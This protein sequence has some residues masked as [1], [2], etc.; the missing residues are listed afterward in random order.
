MEYTKS[1]YFVRTNN[2]G[3]IAS[4]LMSRVEKPI[5]LCVGDSAGMFPTQK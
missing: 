4:A 1:K 2:P 3:S 5:A